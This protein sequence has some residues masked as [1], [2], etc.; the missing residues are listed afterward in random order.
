MKTTLALLVSLFL[1]SSCAL[2][3]AYVAFVKADRL[4]YEAIGQSWADYVLAD[5]QKSPAQKADCQAL[6]DAWAEDL[7]AQEAR[8]R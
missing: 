8:V 1:L 4:R 7:A 6:L 5:P 3:P 2:D